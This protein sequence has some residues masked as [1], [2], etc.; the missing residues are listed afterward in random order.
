MIFC[1][2][3]IILLEIRDLLFPLGI[4]YTPCASLS[5]L[6]IC[7]VTIPKLEIRKTEYGHPHLRK[8]PDNGDSERSSI[9]L[10][11]IFA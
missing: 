4:F 9:R 8:V 11:R 6:L 3:I 5:R 1:K 2:P 10:V 7:K